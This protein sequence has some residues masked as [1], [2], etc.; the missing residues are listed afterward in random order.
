MREENKQMRILSAIGIILVVAGHLGYSLFD[1]GGLFPYYSFPCVYFPVC[2]RLFLSGGSGAH[3][4][5]DIVKS[6]KRCCFLISSGI[7][8]M[9]FWQS[10]APHRLFHWRRT[11][12][13]ESLYR[14]VRERASVS[15]SVPGMVCPGTVFD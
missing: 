15:V 5:D 7:W 8:S 10:S 12:A 14:A 9:E 2:F 6:A 3:C 4:F 13:V 1:V 11:D